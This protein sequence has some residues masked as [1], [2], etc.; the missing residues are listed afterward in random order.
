MSILHAF[1]VLISRDC[2]QLDG[3]EAKRLEDLNAGASA[4]GADDETKA[5]YCVSM[6]AKNDV[7]F[8]FLCFSV[9]GLSISG[10]ASCHRCMMPYF[11]RCFFGFAC[12]PTMICRRVCDWFPKCVVGFAASVLCSCM[13]V[14]VHLNPSSW[15]PV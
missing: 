15:G 9:F 6:Y 11:D 8:V 5:R 13:R 3:L 1:I 12:F 2:A 10:L 14:F 7:V 4:E